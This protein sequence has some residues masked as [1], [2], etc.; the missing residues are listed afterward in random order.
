MNWTRSTDSGPKS[1]NTRQELQPLV[2]TNGIDADTGASCDFTYAKLCQVHNT[3][4][5]EDKYRLLSQLQSQL[6]N[7]SSHFD[8]MRGL[9]ADTKPD[10]ACFDG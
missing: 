7:S 10:V 4:P 8:K 3:L 1:R 2:V 9:R 6:L 5:Q